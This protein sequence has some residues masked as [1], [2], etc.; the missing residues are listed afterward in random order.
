MIKVMM[1]HHFTK[2][3]TTL[4]IPSIPDDLITLFAPLEPTV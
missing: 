3:Q 1:I 4:N 2:P